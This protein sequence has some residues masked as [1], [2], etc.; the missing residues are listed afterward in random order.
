MIA[1]TAE[2]T[3]GKPTGLLTALTLAWLKVSH[4]FSALTSN[5]PWRC[6]FHKQRAFDYGFGGGFFLLPQKHIILGSF[7]GQAEE[8]D[9]QCWHSQSLAKMDL[10]NI[11]FNGDSTCDQIY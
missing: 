10:Q 6:S 1:E 9:G 4:S 7:P 5:I 8:A 3:F 2:T 11:H